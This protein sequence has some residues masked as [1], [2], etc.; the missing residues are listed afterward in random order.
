MHDVGAPDVG[1]AYSWSITFDYLYGPPASG[2]WVPNGPGSGLYTDAAA[3]T[4]YTGTP[5]NTVYAKPA[6]STTYK[7]TVTSIGP[8]ATPTF[9]NP[10]LITI[11]DGSTGTPYPAGI[12]VSGLPTTGV[13]VNSVTLSGIAIHGLMISISCY[14]L[15]LV[16]T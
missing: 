12:N 4:V 14:S 13:V 7:V 5:I 3:T 16:L 9:S 8:D 1:N 15:Q 10:A 2:V 6:A 11:N